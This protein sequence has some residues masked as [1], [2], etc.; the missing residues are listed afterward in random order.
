MHGKKRTS[1][2][3]KSADKQPGK[4]GRPPI[5]DPK[6]HPQ[7]AKALCAKGLTTAELVLAF[8]VAISTIWMWKIS[9]P[10]FFESCKV[11]S[12]RRPI[13]SRAPVRAR[14]WLHARR[15]SCRRAPNRT[16]STS[17]QIRALAS[18]G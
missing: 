2:K 15:Y 10:L 14:R 7:A 3:T 11:G 12:K 6:I 16:P 17:R 9:H 1:L 18:F 4:G 13:A 8:D 5:Y